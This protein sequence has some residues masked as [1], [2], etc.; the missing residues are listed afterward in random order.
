[1]EDDDSRHGLVVFCRTVSFYA[2][3]KRL[4]LSKLLKLRV[5][6]R[7]VGAVKTPA[8]YAVPTH[9]VSR[10]QT[11]LRSPGHWQVHLS[12]YSGVTYAEIVWSSFPPVSFLFISS[13]RVNPK[14]LIPLTNSIALTCSVRGGGDQRSH[15]AF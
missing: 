8:S 7:S 10:V 15:S 5:N 1:M 2:G 11:A 9:R 14:K 3:L 12:S 4:H 13:M 6:R